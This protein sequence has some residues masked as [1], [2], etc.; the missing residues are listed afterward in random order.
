LNGWTASRRIEGWDVHDGHLICLGENSGYL[1][2]EGQF[3]N[4]R[5]ELEYKTSPQVNSGVFFR[6][7]DRDDPVNTGFEMQILDTHDQA[8]M[9]KNSCGA[10]YGLVEPSV[11][12]VRPA[13]EWNQVTIRCMGSEVQLALNGIVVVEA[14]LDRWTEAGQNPDGT[15]NKNK[16]AW[17]DHRRKGHI[18]LQ[19]HRGY[20]EFRNVKIV[21]L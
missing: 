11:N 4:F 1:Y 7:S 21:E 20:I 17:K 6:V 10:L 9:K 12:A 2:S 19:D 15:T 16:Y 13:G 3:E 14:D 5:L 18:G 8:E